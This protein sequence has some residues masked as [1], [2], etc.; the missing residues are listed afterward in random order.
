[1]ASNVAR[2]LAQ[3]SLIEFVNSSPCFVPQA[4]TQSARQKRAPAQTPANTYLKATT[5][6]T[7][8]ALFTVTR[9]LY[10]ADSLYFPQNPQGPPRKSGAAHVCS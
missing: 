8:K 5:A 4:P 10:H 7:P 3:I 1:M 9:L 6:L 2:S